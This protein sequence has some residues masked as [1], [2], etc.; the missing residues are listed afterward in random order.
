MVT[1]T[2]AAAATDADTAFMTRALFL[3]ERGRGR[4]TPNPIVGAVVVTADGIVAGHGAHLA[5]G[6]PHAEVVALDRAGALASGATLYC[7]LEPCAHV[8]RTGPCVER[9]V[10][11]GIARVVA[12]V[13][14]PNPR[15]AGQGFAYLRAHGVEVV[16]GVGQ[17]LAVSQNA[18]FFTWIQK[19]RPLVVLKAAVSR[20]GFV[21]AVGH[22]VQ[23]TGVTADRYFHRQRA[24]IDAIAVGSGTVLTDDPSLTARGAFR[25]RPLTRVIFDWRGRV[26]ATA[27][28]FST[29]D[30]GPVIMILRR[31]AAEASL[32][33]I[34]D[35]EARG[36][37]V[38]VFEEVALEPVLEWLARREILTLLVEGGP[39]LHDHFL[40]AGLADRVQWVVTPATLGDGV[41]LHDAPHAVLWDAP[42]RVRLLGE[43][44][45]IEFDVHGPH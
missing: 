38:E 40:K 15:V 19:R 36:V 20:D 2:P 43:D 22:R 5:A 13:Q 1:G 14:D 37:T 23:L 32:A 7:T 44:T 31:A 4:T 8:G 39:K 41:P 27:R 9:I 21:G 35:L 33:R 6:G 25:S 24:E 26:P 10:A 12:A 42:P 3:A 17:D 28:V 11:A 30:S 16:E 34:A 18:A 45:L 29:L